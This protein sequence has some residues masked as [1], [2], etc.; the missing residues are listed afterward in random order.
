MSNENN[1][2]TAFLPPEPTVDSPTDRPATL[3]EV[4]DM[5]QKILANEHPSLEEQRRAA[6]AIRRSRIAAGAYTAPKA[7]KAKG[8]SHQMSDEEAAALFDSLGGE[9]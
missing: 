5:R 2:L 3:E 8:K 4:L 1:P 6:I 9:K 7:K